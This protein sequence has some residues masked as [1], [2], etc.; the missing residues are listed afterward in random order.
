M[1]PAVIEKI[2]VNHALA[3]PV[4]TPIIVV[5]EIIDKLLLV[6]LKATNILSM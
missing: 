2:K 5:K 3:I 4:G 1:I 6:T